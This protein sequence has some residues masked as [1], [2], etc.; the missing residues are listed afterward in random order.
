MGLKFNNKI[1]LAA[2]MDKNGDYIDSLAQIGFGFIEVGTVTPLPQKGNPKPRIFRIS[3]KEGIINRMGFN[4]LGIDYLVSNIKKSKFKGIIGVN[5]GKNKHTKIE[6]AIKDYLFCIEK[7]YCYAGYIA[8][9]ISSPNTINLRKLQYGKLFKNLL[10]N[11]K[12]KQKEMENRYSKYVPIAIKISPDLSEEELIYVSN[13]LINYKIDA[14][15]ATNTTLD[16]SLILGTKNSTQ[17]GGLSGLPLQKK[18]LM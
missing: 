17:E 3:S 9:N 11:I 1:G 2:G 7:V 16:R 15:I 5:I 14:V 12:K 8:I 13:Q 18:A 6:D 4:N 10:K